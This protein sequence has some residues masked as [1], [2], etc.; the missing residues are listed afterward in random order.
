MTLNHTPGPWKTVFRPK[1]KHYIVYH[2]NTAHSGVNIVTKAESEADAKLIAASPDLLQA[3][4][5]AVWLLRANKMTSSGAYMMLVVAIE[6]A[7]GLHI[8]AILK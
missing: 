1:R 8:D 2:E 3:S 6:K 7:T 5:D 4:I